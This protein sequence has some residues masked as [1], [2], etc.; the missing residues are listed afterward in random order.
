MPG[1]EYFGLNHDTVMVLR[2]P[3]SDYSEA[4]SRYLDE[5]GNNQAELATAVGT[6]QASIS[7]YAADARFPSRELAAAIDRA[8]A[9]R[10]PV[11]LWISTATKKFGLAA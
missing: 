1:A 11:S 6:S 4:L 7:R 9:G 5:K 2:W 3:M 8:T 10:V